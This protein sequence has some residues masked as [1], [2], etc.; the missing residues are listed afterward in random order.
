MNDVTLVGVKYFRGTMCKG[1][2][3][4]RYFG[5]TEGRGS[6]NLQ[7]YQKVTQNSIKET[8]KAKQISC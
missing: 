7:N 5:V 2:S 4:N 1:L 3:K 6:E 8:Q